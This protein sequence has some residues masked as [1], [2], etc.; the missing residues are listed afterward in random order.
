MTSGT[1]GRGHI[2]AID[3]LRAVAVIAVLLFHADIGVAPGGFLGVSLFFTLSGYLIT[4]LLL[5]E[6][7][8][9]GTI[10]IR[11]FYARRWRRLIP[12]A[13]LAIAG[14]LAAW[15]VWSASQLDALPGDALAALGNVANWRF[16]FAER[17][18]QDLFIG[19]PSPLAH[20]WSLAIEE[21][22]YAVM[23]LIALLC[24]RRSRRTLAFVA[25]LMLLASIA[26][27]LLT[28][29]RNLVYNGTHTRA[30]ELLVGVLLA[31]YAPRLNR[32]AHALI[33]WGALAVFGAIVAT[34]AVTDGWLY[35]GGLPAFSVV[36]A[37]LVL[38][39]ITPRR[40]ALTTLLATRPLVAVGRWSYA[41]YLVHWP[42]YLALDG[43]RT[44]LSPWPLLLTRAVTAVAVAAVITALVERPI[45]TRRI[46]LR[47]RTGSIASLAA[48]ATIVAACVALPA[49]TFS[50]NEELL[51]AGNDGH[52]VFNEQPTDTTS[53]PIVVPPV[54]V[55]GSGIGV[56][57][58]LRAR[59]VSVIDATDQNCPL[60]PATETKLVTNKVVD[61][62]RCADAASW[63]AAA[64]DAGVTEVVVTFG[65]IDEGVVR[66]VTEVG[67]PDAT[68]Y[69]G[70]ATRS[71]HVADA[72]NRFWDSIPGTLHVQLLRIGDQRTALQS[73]LTKFAASRSVLAALHFSVGSVVDSLQASGADDGQALR[74][75][76]VG[77]ST[78]VILASALH[79][80]APTAAVV[81]IGANGC[82]VVAVEAVRSSTSEPWQDVECAPTTPAVAEQLTTFRPDVVVLMVSGVE[83]LHQRY[84]GD[85]GDHIA[86]DPQFTAAHD[87]YL[88]TLTELLA[89]RQVPLLIA[90]CPQLVASDFVR[91]ESASPERIA[92]WNAQVQRWIDNSAVDG[93]TEVAL[94][95]YADAINARQATHP[96]EGVLLD[97]IHA[98][99]HIL[100]EII[101]TELLA[102][103]IT[104]AG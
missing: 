92:L 19:R 44:G 69:L 70:L 56:P 25:G 88:R 67:F 89:E 62:S 8:V 4:T 87:E 72:L 68:D 1:A 27:N 11:Q 73:E 49:P 52:I 35:H 37:A 34:T 83:L 59:G 45:R 22:F 100:A 10:S 32:L 5:R 84:P 30:G 12:S 55:V 42:I 43:E 78:S 41:L 99:V 81:W 20:F 33:S 51:A 50:D 7:R 17:S 71:R 15:L 54:L 9:S 103:L 64:T 85:D 75:M 77:D 102:V 13:W 36:S 53:P 90:D 101:R 29:D 104:A 58:L 86:G 21:Q 96:H 91:E 18:Y 80:A 47:P 26:A 66:Q 74:V 57:Q 3:G 82:P 98:D 65:A 40:A 28:D 93:S 23:P 95:P 14:V 39:V 38:A 16:A 24:L 6:H 63:L 2:D 94:F 97:G 60:T 61:T 76:V 79:R 31:L 48:A 46:F